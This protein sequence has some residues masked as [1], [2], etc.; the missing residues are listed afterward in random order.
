MTALYYI[1]HHFTVSAVVV[2][3]IVIVIVIGIL[4]GIFH[5]QITVS[6]LLGLWRKIRG[7][8]L[9]RNAPSLLAYLLLDQLC[10]TSPRPD[11]RDA[12]QE[13][14]SGCADKNSSWAMFLHTIIDWS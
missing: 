3:V 9:L 7:R 13:S 10:A 4:V 14:L 5:V 12:S 8:G 2:I 1:G 6:R 11:R